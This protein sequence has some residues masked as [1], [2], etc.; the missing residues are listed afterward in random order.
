MAKVLQRAVS[1]FYFSWSHKLITW[2]LLNDWKALLVTVKW[3]FLNPKILK[4]LF[5]CVKKSLC[6]FKQKIGVFNIKS[7]Q[8]RPKLYNLIMFRNV[9]SLFLK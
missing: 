2:S 8:I 1:F 6:F 5:Y 9:P 4:S 7:N 3:K